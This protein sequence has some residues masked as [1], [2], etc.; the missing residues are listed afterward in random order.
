MATGY[1]SYDF[2]KPLKVTGINSTGW[3]GTNIY[4]N[5]YLNTIT[6]VG[7]TGATTTINNDMTIQGSL[8]L[9]GGFTGISSAGGAATFTNVTVNNTL[10]VSGTGTYGHTTTPA[11]SVAT[12][13]TYSDG[14]TNTAVP[15]IVPLASLTTL[16]TTYVP[17]S[18]GWNSVALSSSGQYQTAVQDSRVAPSIRYLIVAGGGSGGNDQAAGGGAGGLL[19]GSFTLSSGLVISTSVGEGGAFKTGAQAQ[20]N[21]GS[22]STLTATGISLSAT[23]GGGGGCGDANLAGLPGGSGGGGGAD[24]GFLNGGSGVA[25]QGYAGGNGSTDS[26]TWRNSGGGGGAGGVGGDGIGPGE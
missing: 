4:W 11:L 6:P 25:G 8:Y 15:A 19:S 13:I 16:T 10:T 18:S 7:P 14:T 5:S 2:N 17:L 21:S 26:S 23:G 3:T 1:Y 12:N 9:S 22:N 24:A 20:G